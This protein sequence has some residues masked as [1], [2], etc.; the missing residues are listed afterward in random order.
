MSNYKFHYEQKGYVVI[1]NVLNNSEIQNLRKLVKKYFIKRKDENRINVSSCYRKPEITK[2]V[3]NKKLLK[4]CRQI[5]GKQF[6][7]NELEV[8][9]N[10]FPENSKVPPHY[11]GQSQKN[12]NFFK[13]SSYKALKLGIY[14]QDTCD[15]YGGGINVVPNTHKYFPFKSKLQRFENLFKKLSSLLAKKVN[16]KAGDAILFNHKL[17]HRGIWPLTFKS[18]NQKPSQECINKL[19]LNNEKIVVYWNVLNKNSSN[20]FLENS[21]KRS[22]QQEVLSRHHLHNYFTDY[23]SLSFPKDYNKEF[24]NKLNKEKIL[25]STLD[26]RK[27]KLIK[28]INNNILK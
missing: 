26:D 16:I 7:I 11:D 21:F 9:Y 1:K 12:D 17:L 5:I 6:F 18:F 14:L 2:L 20:K 13:S 28:Y 22:V 27:I 8:Q 4:A 25:I 15:I 3:L 24:V 23:L 19:M 10:S